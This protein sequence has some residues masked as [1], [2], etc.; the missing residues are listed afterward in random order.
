MLLR[1]GRARCTRPSGGSGCGCGSTRRSASWCRAWPTWCAGCSRTRRTS[2]FVRHRFAEGRALDELLRRARRRR[3]CPARRRAAGRA[4]T[5]PADPAPY[6]PEPVREWRRG[7][8]AGRVRRG[9]RRGA[10]RPA[11]SR[12]RRSSTASGCARAATIDVGRPGADRPASSPRSA[13]CGGGRGRRARSRPRSRRADAL[14]AHAGRASGPRCCSGRRQWMRRAPRRARRPRGASR[15]AS[16]GTRPTPT[17]ARPSTSASTTAA[18][19]C[20]S[21]A[22]AADLVQSPPGE[23]NRL[24]YQGK[25][26][27]VVIAPWNFPLAIPTGMTVAALV[28]GQPGDPQAGRADAGGRRRRLVEAL[29]GRRAR[30]RAWSSSCPASARRSA[31]ALVEH[32]D[33]AVIA[34]TGSKAVGLSIIQQ[35]AV[36]RPG[37]RHVKRVV[38]E[39]G[40]K[41]AADRRRRR[42]SRPGR[43]RPSSYSAFGY[44]GQKCS[45]GQPAHRPRRGLRRRSSSGWSAP[46]ASC[47]SATPPTPAVQVGPGHRRRRPR[48]A[49]AAASRRPPA[50][51]R[52]RLAGDDVPDRRAGSCGPT[53]VAG[54]DPATRRS[55]ATRSSARC[56]PCCGPRDLDHALALA[57]DT[58]YALTAGCFSRSPAAHPR[59]PPPSCGPATSTSTGRI[60]GAVVGRQPFG[61]Y[62]MS[63]VGSKAGGPD[64]LLQFLDPRVVT[65]NTLRQGFAPECDLG[66]SDGLVCL[67]LAQPSGGSTTERQDG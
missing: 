61:G 39:M 56:S 15:R 17:C 5:D 2:R 13:S 48:A 18:R 51:A 53:I 3:S 33:V 19:C 60:T 28:A 64:Y 21:T 57:N 41:N 12:C 10:R 43:A 32:P 52:S 63:G 29:R 40:G 9:G 62:G 8:G 59:G 4:A 50:R 24:R 26:V 38:A 67:G 14:A 23:A 58:D 30:R 27:A 49:R 7:V 42:R 55:P 34:F 45:A 11:A 35:A 66:W 54:D 25:G 65:E 16:R 6:E 44:A 46:P 20:A 37:Q 31:P 47:W 36:A 22:P 1:H